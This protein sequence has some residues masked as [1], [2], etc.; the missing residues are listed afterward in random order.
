MIELSNKALDGLWRSAGLAMGWLDPEVEA[1]RQDRLVE[2]L[3]DGTSDLMTPEYGTGWKRR[4]PDEV[5]EVEDTDVMREVAVAADLSLR[6]PPFHERRPLMREVGSSWTI[7]DKGMTGRPWTRVL[8]LEIECPGGDPTFER[9]VTRRHLHPRRVRWEGWH[10]AELLKQKMQILGT[11]V[12]WP[13]EGECYGR[14]NR[15]HRCRVM[16]DKRPGSS[17]I[18]RPDIELRERFYEYM[19]NH[20]TRARVDKRTRGNPYNGNDAL[21]LLHLKVWLALRGAGQDLD[22][23]RVLTKIPNRPTKVQ[24][25]ERGELRDILA[26]LWDDV[27]VTHLAEVLTCRRDS[28]RTLMGERADERTQPARPGKPTTVH[29]ASCIEGVVRFRRSNGSRQTYLRLVEDMSD[30]GHLLAA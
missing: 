18:V 14:D 27:T 28:L 13:L 23:A 30:V 5:D 29:V 10:P 11:R 20:K 8:T 16:S 2:D 24:V 1:W 4:R 25:G 3:F 17:S 9:P 21:R 26:P 15:L 6:R 12:W 19:T 7:G 22:W